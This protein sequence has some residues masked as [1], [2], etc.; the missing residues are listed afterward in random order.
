[1]INKNFERF[2]DIREYV[3]TVYPSGEYGALQQANKPNSWQTVV[4]PAW[5]GTKG[6]RIG[7]II[8][9]W[10]LSAPGSRASSNSPIPSPSSAF[11]AGYL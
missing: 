4:Q 7:V 10:E 5:Q 9:K 3:T 8:R 2:E 6:E 11:H 1:M